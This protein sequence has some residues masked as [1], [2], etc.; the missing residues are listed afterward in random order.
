MKTRKTVDDLIADYINS[1]KPRI[2]ITNVFSSA[3]KVIDS[4]LKI[5]KSEDKDIG[6]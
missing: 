5:E 6:E 4:R 3:I 1:G 2:L